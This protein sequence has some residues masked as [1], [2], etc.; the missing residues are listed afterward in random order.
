MIS[1]V[2]P[3][4]SSTHSSMSPESQFRSKR[5]KSR[6]GLTSGDQSAVEPPGPFPNP[7]VKRRSADGIGTI[8]PVRVGRCQV[9]ARL[10]EIGVGLF[11][12]L[13]IRISRISSRRKRSK[14]QTHDASGF[15][16]LS[17]IR[18]SLASWR[19]RS[20]AIPVRFSELPK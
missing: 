10:Q 13:I 9:Y 2:S 7:E 11:F 19:Q 14:N 17:Y 6:A 18:N 16:L 5:Q 1:Y 8:G 20:E 12:C 15:A 3:G 4:P